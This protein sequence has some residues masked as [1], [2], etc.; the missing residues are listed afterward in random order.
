M[1][2]L[3]VEIPI[4]GKRYDFQ[5]DEYVPLGE[6]KK[7]IT[8]MICRKEQCPLQEIRTDCLCGSPTVHCLDRSCQPVSAGCVPEIR[9]CLYKRA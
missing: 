7:E 8:D 6:V 1:I 3:E 9:S 5:I 4:M 2:I